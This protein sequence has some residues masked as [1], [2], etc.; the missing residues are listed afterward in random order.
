MSS[1]SRS[2]HATSGRSAT[3]SLC[4][5]IARSLPTCRSVISWP[6]RHPLVLARSST[7]PVRLPRIR[8]CRRRLCPLSRRIR[9]ACAPVSALER[10]RLRGVLARA[11]LQ[12]LARHTTTHRCRR[13]LCCTMLSDR[14]LNAIRFICSR[15]PSPPLPAPVLTPSRSHNC[16]H[17]QC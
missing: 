14:E 7:S 1:V 5:L 15:R 9:R 6:S 13:Q 8:R 17:S 16:S 2:K 12:A 3:G 10:Q 4:W 11:S